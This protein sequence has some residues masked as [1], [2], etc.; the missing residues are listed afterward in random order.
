[1]NL[2][3]LSRRGESED[4]AMARAQ[5][6]RAADL[7]T[8]LVASFAERLK[9]VGT[10][11]DAFDTLIAEIERDARVKSAE[12]IAIAKAYAGASKKIG[13]RNA[14]AD[15]IRKR[16]VEL[17]RFDAKNELAAKSRPW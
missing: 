12:F 17:I 4:E 3:W 16:F 11:R 7:D 2:G 8:K 6:A 14:A 1:M 5:K 10:D 13:S 9:G 15:A